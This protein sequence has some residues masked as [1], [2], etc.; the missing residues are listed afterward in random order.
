M[1]KATVWPREFSLLISLSSSYLSV[2]TKRNGILR[3][4]IKCF[5]LYIVLKYAYNIIGTE[6]EKSCEM[7][8]KVHS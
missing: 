7:Y 6:A 1:E 4:W 3:K 8:K 2:R 5:H